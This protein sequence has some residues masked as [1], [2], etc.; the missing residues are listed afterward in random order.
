M[1]ENKAELGPKKVDRKPGVKGPGPDTSK[2]VNVL[3]LP[4]VQ[5]KCDNITWQEVKILK[6]LTVKEANPSNQQPKEVK[7]VI[8]DAIACTRCGSI[9][10]DGV[11]VI[12]LRKEGE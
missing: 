7:H 9:L 2:T 10:S 3:D 4:T 6:T 11:P 1:P 12:R 5:C 8:V